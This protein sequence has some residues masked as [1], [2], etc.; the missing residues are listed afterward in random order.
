MSDQKLRILFLCTGNTARSL[1]AEAIANQTYGPRIEAVS[2]GS[3]PADE[4][5]PR[6]LEVIEHNGLATDGL[7]PKGVQTCANHH[8]DLVITLCDYARQE[9][10]P[11]FPGSPPQ[12]H[13]G[14]PDPAASESEAIFEAV[15]DGLVDAIGILINAPNPSLTGRAAEAGR[16][17]FRR[18]APKAI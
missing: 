12:A 14:F 4:A 2:A 13:W 9:P 17:V 6:T 11:I 10:C 8:F 1:M 15:F 7:H 3:R 18:F 16:E 5:N